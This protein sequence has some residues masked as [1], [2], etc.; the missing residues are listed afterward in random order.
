MLA[1]TQLFLIGLGLG[2]FVLH[3]LAVP[4]GVWP[5]LLAA[6]AVNLVWSGC[7]VVV[8]TRRHSAA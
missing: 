6:L 8:A 5:A 7:I 2:A 4:L 3:Y 1:H